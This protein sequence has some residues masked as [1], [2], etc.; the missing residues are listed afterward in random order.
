M[1]LGLLAALALSGC[2]TLTPWVDKSS[3]EVAKVIVKY[4]EEVSPVIRMRLRDEINSKLDGST[5]VI[6][7][8]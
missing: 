4:C 7:C 1:L 5:V 8:K 2:S 3:D 6:T